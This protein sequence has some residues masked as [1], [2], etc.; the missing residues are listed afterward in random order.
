MTFSAKSKTRRHGRRHGRQ[1]RRHARQTKRHVRQT[2]RHGR[3]TR[4]Q[5]KRLHKGGSIFKLFEKEKF[6]TTEKKYLLE[7]FSSDAKLKDK[8]KRQIITL[9]NEYN[10]LKNKILKYN[11]TKYYNAIGN[12]DIDI[13]RSK[14]SFQEAFE[15]FNKNIQLLKQILNQIEYELTPE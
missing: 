5:T 2:K 14:V 4:R 11:I 9:N 3:Q 12:I 8:E 6:T 10:E 7:Q 13:K 1:T 15:S